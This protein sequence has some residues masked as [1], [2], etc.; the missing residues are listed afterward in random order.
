MAELAY[1]ESPGK[2]AYNTFRGELYGTRD[3]NSFT[4]E[5]DE[6]SPE[7]KE[8]W[9]IVAAKVAKTTLENYKALLQKTESVKGLPAPKAREN[10]FMLARNPEGMISAEFSNGDRSYGRG[11]ILWTFAKFYVSR[12]RRRERFDI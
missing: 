7:L 3:E 12:A 6:L 10:E 9:T 8:A 4:Q 11:N 2:A 1:Q 5:W